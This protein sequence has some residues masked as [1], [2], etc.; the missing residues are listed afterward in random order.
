MLES[1]LEIVQLIEGRRHR[2]K[3]MVQ[4]TSLDMITVSG[5]CKN[6]VTGRQR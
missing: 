5:N 4:C 6:K 1:E 3:A 2:E